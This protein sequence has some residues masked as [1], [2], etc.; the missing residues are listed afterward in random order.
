MRVEQ[1]GVLRDYGCS[2][3]LPAWLSAC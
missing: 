3:L 1:Q 2:D